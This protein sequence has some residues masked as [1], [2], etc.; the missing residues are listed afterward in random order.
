[1]AASLLRLNPRDCVNKPLW[2]EIRIKEITSALDEAMESRD[3]VK[4]QLRL[5]RETSE[6]VVN[7]YAASLST[8]AG[9][10]IGAVIVLNDITE[11]AYLSRVRT[12]FVANASHELKTPI[13]AIRGLAETV[14]S[15]EE[16]ERSDVVK[17]MERIH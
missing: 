8:E 13:T 1:A 15:D 6:L 11:L 9:D 5:S 17:F 2:Q 7:I 10:P 16:I 4:S 3:V 14:L 12:D